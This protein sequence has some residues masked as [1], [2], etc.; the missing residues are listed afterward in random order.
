M[1]SAKFIGVGFIVAG[2]LALVPALAMFTVGP[3]GQR[4][5]CRPL[6][7]VYDFAASAFS[8][9]TANVASGLIWI[10]VAATM[11]AVGIRTWQRG[12]GRNAV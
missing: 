9:T 5:M 10:A 3:L 1:F 12:K 8:V 2:L 7:A 4:R 6:C 11:V